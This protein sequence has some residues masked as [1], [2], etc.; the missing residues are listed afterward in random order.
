M[1][2]ATLTLALAVSPLAAAP[3]LAQAPAAAAQPPA[4][5]YAVDLTH[6]ALTWKV[7]HQGLAPY[8]ARFT[9]F[10]ADLSFDPA[11]VTRSKLIVVVDPT[12]VETD[13]ARTRPAGNTTD[14]NKE[15]AED[16]RFFNSGKHREIRFVST[17]ITKSSETTG[18]VTG[19]LT[20]LGV[21]KPVTLDVTFHGHRNDPRV[22]KHK[23]GF[24]ATG[25]LKRSDFGMSFG[26]AFL[27]DEV[28]LDIAAEFV[29]K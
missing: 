17:N 4:G 6:A 2:L 3:A 1:R 26:Q 27:G 20:F 10:T 18:K 7:M 28:T 24:S 12:S 9:N 19:D 11:D 14:F 25:K 29:Q 22:Q 8:F 13:Y 5:A 16:A 15:L 23:I 21:T